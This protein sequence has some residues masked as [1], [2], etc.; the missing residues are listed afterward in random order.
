M[1]DYKPISL[2]PI[3]LFCLWGFLSVWWGS[4]VYD[5][6]M[7]QIHAHATAGIIVRASELLGII[8]CS[9]VFAKFLYN[10]HRQRV[11]AKENAKCFFIIGYF[12]MLPYLTDFIVN[13]CFDEWESIRHDEPWVGIALF[14]VVL[15]EVFKYGVQLQEEKEL[16]I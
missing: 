11:F 7:E 10:C 13:L 14:M 2:H 3:S 1:E 4:E 5:M 9:L 12:M 16:T 8:I 15:S 6:M